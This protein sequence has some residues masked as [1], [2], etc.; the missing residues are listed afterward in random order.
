MTSAIRPRSAK[1]FTIVE[2]LV[3][4]VISLV[5]SAA[6]WTFYRSQLRAL[7]DQSARLDA[8]EAARAA[9]A[10][11]A[12]EI[13]KAGLDPLADPPAGVAFTTPGAKGVSDARP[14]RLLVQWDKNSSGAI[15]TGAADP[16]AESV[17]YSYDGVNQQILRTVNGTA[18]ALIKNVAAGGLSFRYFDANGN[19]LTPTGSP[20]ELS[21][22]DRDAVAVILVSL[23]VQA[24]RAT[25]PTAVKLSAR[26]TLRNRVLGRL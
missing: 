21:A 20:A 10:F 3:A 23:T 15:E 17:E 26:A 14:E 1:G 13:R 4:T 24:A 19:V 2:L 12:R 5:L 25:Q 16:D 22:S 8:D 9:V 18:Q 7:I 6:G 11:M